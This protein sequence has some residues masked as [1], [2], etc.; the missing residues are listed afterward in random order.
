[1]ARWVS[2]GINPR[3]LLFPQVCRYIFIMNEQRNSGYWQRFPVAAKLFVT[4][5][6]EH[7]KRINC[8]LFNSS[9]VMTPLEIFLFYKLNILILKRNI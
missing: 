8:S 2:P 6:T 7:S 3:D 5:Q 1:M 9:Y 4:V